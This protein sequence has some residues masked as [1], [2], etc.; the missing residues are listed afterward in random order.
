MRGTIMDYPLTIPGILEHAGRLFRPHEIVSRLPDKSIHRYTYA[1]F[2]RRARLLAEALIKA[3]IKPGDR[4]ATLM[5]NHYAHL[6]T[7]F[8]AP[9]IG[10]VIHTLNLRLHPDDIAYIVN[11]AE[12]R[13]LIVDDVLLP[14]Y[15]QFREQVDIERVIVVRLDGGDL[16]E[17]YEDYE[18]FLETAEGDFD[19]PA[20]DEYDAC[21]MCYTS[22]TTGRPKGVAYSHRAV[23]VHTLAVAA[24]DVFD[25]SMKE[26]LLPVVPM[27]HA[28]AW[29]LAYVAVMTGAKIVFP[30]P[31]L[32]AENLLDLL[33]SERV[34]MTAGVPTVWLALLEA[35]QKER[36]R[37]DLVPG[38]RL[39]VG[40]AACPES[41]IRAFDDLGCTVLHAWGMTEMTP[42]GTSG[43]PTPA[44]ADMD[45]DTQYA[46]RAKQGRP[47]PF[48]GTRVVEGIRHRHALD[49]LLSHAIHHVRLGQPRSF[50]NGRDN[51]NDVMEL[52]TN[53]AF[54]LDPIGPAQCHPISYP[55]P[56]GSNL[57][58]PLIR[59][60]HGMGPS[61]R[62]V[63]EG[64]R[65]A[66]IIQPRLRRPI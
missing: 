35:L 45:K 17:G 6:E 7:Y 48:V 22:G 37:W 40:G 41:M 62:I 27:F 30:G 66:K 24:P 19:Y 13:Y 52:F 53:P 47:L 18:A 33:A 12:D 50:Q 10:A 25:I 44:F 64:F 2:Y 9:C 11:H 1:D 63:V 42:V 58:G 60:V 16:P 31:H 49:G 34:T 28:N 36:D 55:S 59:S 32:D 38:I 65:T 57:L 39:L 61:Y 15:E 20:I 14:L 26:T 29:G 54:R 56:V 8:A 23:V 43:G 3:G 46:I 4:V 21:G 51:V 5:W